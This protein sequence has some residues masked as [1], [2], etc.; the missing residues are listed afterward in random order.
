M[1]S[2]CTLTWQDNFIIIMTINNVEN[3]AASNFIIKFDI[4]VCI[5]IWVRKYAPWVSPA[6]HFSCSSKFLVRL[7]F[8]VLT[9]YCARTQQITR[10]IYTTHHINLKIL[11]IIIIVLK[12]FLFVLIFV[13]ENTCNC[14][15]AWRQM[16]IHILQFA[17]SIYTYTSCDYLPLP[18]P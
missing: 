11:M 14:C 3:Y 13:C 12:L 6:P 1:R 4:Y 5:Y 2:L 17:L 10:R 7:F 16:K 9:N 8:L 15:S 18:Q